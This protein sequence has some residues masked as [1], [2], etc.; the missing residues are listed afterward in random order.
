MPGSRSGPGFRELLKLRDHARKLLC[1]RYTQVEW[2]TYL[3]A[4]EKNGPPHDLFN[5]PIPTAWARLDGGSRICPLYSLHEED[6]QKF[7]VVPVGIEEDR[8][9]KYL[10]GA[11][12]NVE[13]LLADIKGLKR[14]KRVWLGTENESKAKWPHT[15]RRRQPVR[16]N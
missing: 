7:F 1:E 13:N 4:R 16:S 12:E 3:D 14:D 6:P 10:S 11:I 8:R 9:F 15:Q 2:A 5:E